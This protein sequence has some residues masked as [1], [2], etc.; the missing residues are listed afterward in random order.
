[1]KNILNI[2]IVILI[3]ISSE[4]HAGEPFWQYLNQPIGGP[5]NN[6]VYNPENNILYFTS[7]NGIYKS[8]DQGYSWEK[9]FTLPHIS[10]SNLISINSKGSVTGLD[11]SQN[12]LRV[13][14]KKSSDTA[15]T[16]LPNLHYLANTTY[17]VYGFIM[18][19]NDAI[20]L[21]HINDIHDSLFVFT[22][23]NL[24][25]TW[26]ISTFLVD[27]I[28][29]GENFSVNNISFKNNKIVIYGYSNNNSIILM[30]DDFNN[31][32]KKIKL[33]YYITDLSLIGNKL[34][35]IYYD[36][37]SKQSGSIYSTNLGL[38]W[39]KLY[40]GSV[41]INISYN[42]NIYLNGDTIY[43]ITDNGISWEKLAN[44][45][46]RLSF[47]LERTDGSM[48]GW[49]IDGIYRSFDSCKTWNQSTIGYTSEDIKDITFDNQ[50]NIY[51]VNDGVFVSNI[52]GNI[53]KSLGLK[54]LFLNKIIINKK[55][56]IFVCGRDAFGKDGI[57]YRSTDSGQNWE[58][59]T[60]GL[61]AP[62][63]I[64]PVIMDL[65]INKR[66][67]IFAGTSAGSY[68]KS[69]D[70]GDTWIYNQN[71]DSPSPTNCFS[72]NSEGH[73]FCGGFASIFRSTNDGDNW[74]EYDPDTD[75][76]CHDVILSI[77]FDPKDS[78]GWALCMKTTDNGRTW[79]EYDYNDFN[80]DEWPNAIDSLGNYLKIS[81]VSDP[82]GINGV[83]K[84]TDKGKTW[85][86][87]SS[88]IEH[89]NFNFLKVS[90][91]GYYYLGAENGGLYRSRDKFVSVK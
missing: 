72:V 53:L 85:T 54:D 16:Y 6:I 62:S 12:P 34:I 32:W 59:K 41:T 91:D 55:G 58:L 63:G 81:R 43:L 45:R 51:C 73:I 17:N 87:I 83:V 86:N 39:N 90:P 11:L 33:N 13:F 35:A 18:D 52:N 37:H 47:L 40:N 88:G 38:S 24:G 36:S 20:V 69:T 8:N 14:Y 44:G 61:I 65:F 49:G 23:I 79:K 46:N 2:S 50:K 29:E 30:S 77:T 57:L 78:V 64:K 75:M 9:Y 19:T 48:I 7:L 82:W 3:I 70:N 10:Q 26:N 89:S 27:T 84:S 5:V 74:R 1:M 22:S 66:N 42:G 71:S 68:F 60:N 31:S 56:D 67:E 25:K 28:N 21:A 76:F 15:I 80:F 4:V